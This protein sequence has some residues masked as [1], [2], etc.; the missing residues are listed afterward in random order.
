MLENVGLVGR[1]SKQRS[2]VGSS[3]SVRAFER[4][5]EKAGHAVNKLAHVHRISDA[6][7]ASELQRVSV[8]GHRGDAEVASDRGWPVGKATWVPTP[9]QCKPQAT[10]TS[11]CAPT[12]IDVKV[13]CMTIAISIRNSR[14]GAPSA[15]GLSSV[16]RRRRWGFGSRKVTLRILPELAWLIPNLVGESDDLKPRRRLK[17]WSFGAFASKGQLEGNQYRA[18]RRAP[19]LLLHQ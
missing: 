16:Y 11:T 5:S 19:P 2:V 13:T 9:H 10:G 4:P 6:E 18:G 1:R 3:G 15:S 12:L 17:W 14:D 7:L 8:D